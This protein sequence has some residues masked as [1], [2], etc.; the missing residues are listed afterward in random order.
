MHTQAMDPSMRRCSIQVYY[1][2]TLPV[3]TGGNASVAASTFDV[4]QAISDSLITA[5]VALRPF[6]AEEVC[7]CV[8]ICSSAWIM[9]P[10]VSDHTRHLL[11]LRS[12]RNSL[13]ELSST[14]P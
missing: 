4:I 10:N 13:R 2:T 5:A 3:S 9:F 8:R 6:F 1:V 11:L 14:M 12:M 7:A